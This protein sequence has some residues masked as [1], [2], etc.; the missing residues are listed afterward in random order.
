MKLTLDLLI[1]LMMLINV[2][3]KKSVEKDLGNMEEAHDGMIWDMSWHPLGHML[4]TGSNDRS[5]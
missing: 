4:V 2:S 1:I 5:T 3:H